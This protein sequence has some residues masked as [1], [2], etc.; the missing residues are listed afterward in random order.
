MVKDIKVGVMQGRLLPKFNGRYQAHPISY[1]K[2]E[3][4]L[5][6]KKKSRFNRVHIRLQ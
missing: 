2:D 3:F 1:W 4:V 5:V 6:K